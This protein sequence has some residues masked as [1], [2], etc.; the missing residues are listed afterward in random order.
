MVANVKSD[1]VEG[2]LVFKGFDGT[3]IATFDGVNNTLDIAD[4]NVPTGG[5][6]LANGTQAALIADVADAAGAAPD[7]AEFN[8]AA[9]AINAIIDALQGVGIVATA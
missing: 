7:A 3:V 1:W 4:L 5:T 6:I 2:K 9:D 8:A